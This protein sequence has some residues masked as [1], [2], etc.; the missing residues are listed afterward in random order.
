MIVC[1]RQDELVVGRV[2]H[3]RS[4]LGE[5][6]HLMSFTWKIPRRSL[7][8]LHLKFTHF[9]SLKEIEKKKNWN[10]GNERCQD[11][12]ILHYDEFCQ[13]NYGWLNIPCVLHWQLFERDVEHAFCNPCNPQVLR[14]QL[15]CA[16]RELPLKGICVK[17]VAKHYDVCNVNWKYQFGH[18][19]GICLYDHLSGTWFQWPEGIGEDS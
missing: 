3:W 9:L 5:K 18:T 15:P 16:A 11:V 1:C 12:K 10:G 8:F 13:G 6:D 17:L 4:Y 7:P 14:L 19:A 2:H